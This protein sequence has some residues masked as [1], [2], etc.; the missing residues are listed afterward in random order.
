MIKKMNEKTMQ[1]MT[2]EQNEHVKQIRKEDAQAQCLL[3]LFYL[4]NHNILKFR[5]RFDKQ[6][7]KNLKRLVSSQKLL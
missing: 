4:S 7:L 5:N 3:I 1:L 6:D 2:I